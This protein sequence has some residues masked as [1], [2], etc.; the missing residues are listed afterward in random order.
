VKASFPLFVVLA[1]FVNTS[2]LKAS[3]NKIL[4]GDFET[5]DLTGWTTTSPDPS[6]VLNGT[7]GIESF[8]SYFY[9]AGQTAFSEVV[10]AIDVSD[11]SSDIDSGVAEATLSGYLG[12]W[13]ND[14]IIVVEASFFNSID[15]DLGN[16]ISISAIDNPLLSSGSLGLTNDGNLET[17]I[18]DIPVGARSIIM[19][20]RS[21]RTLGSDNDGYADNL[22]IVVSVP[23][24]STNALLL[25]ASIL[26]YT[27]QRRRK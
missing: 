15:E 12:S 1:L 10:Q 11:L 13:S 16:T 5:G 20:I 8:G 6:T 18:G 21:Q 23:E 22:S 14:D 19:K 25:G 7:F 4:N 9:R 3:I 27:C 2:D 17:T 24:P 26:G